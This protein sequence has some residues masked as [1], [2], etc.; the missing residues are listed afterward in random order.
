MRSSGY[1]RRRSCG[2]RLVH[3][4]DLVYGAGAGGFGMDWR[5]DS[6]PGAYGAA[7]ISPAA[8]CRMR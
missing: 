7:G 1:S 3:C 4:W 5:G 6:G 2:L 8:M